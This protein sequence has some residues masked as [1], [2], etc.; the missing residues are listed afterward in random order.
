MDE[1]FLE[2]A[3]WLALGAAGFSGIALAIAMALDRTK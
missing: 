1:Q 2:W 3:L